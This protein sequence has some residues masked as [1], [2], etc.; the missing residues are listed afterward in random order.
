MDELD[1]TGAEAIRLGELKHKVIRNWGK[2]NRLEGGKSEI[3]VED[4]PPLGTNTNGNS[5]HT[6]V[7][8]GGSQRRS[9][10]TVNENDE[11]AQDRVIPSRTKITRKEGSARPG[12]EGLSQEELDEM[13]NDSQADMEEDQ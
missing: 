9:G 13:E 12:T 5:P 1:Q 11:G 6:P 10:I 4:D 3:R 2:E 7:S 8:I